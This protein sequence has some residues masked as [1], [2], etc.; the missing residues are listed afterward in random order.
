VN[1]IV[2]SSNGDGGTIPCLEDPRRVR[3]QSFASRLIETWSTILGAPHKVDDI[4]REGLSHGS[5]VSGV[6]GRFALAGLR[7][8][9]RGIL[10]PGRCP[11]LA[12]GTPSAYMQRPADCR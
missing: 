9:C 4:F 11:G 12:C 6:R 3:E 1:V 2:V 7:R 10:P 8:N 5:T